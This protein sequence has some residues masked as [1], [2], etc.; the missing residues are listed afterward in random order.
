MK[1]FI[2]TNGRQYKA[3]EKKDPSDAEI[4]FPPQD[5]LNALPDDGSSMNFID[6]NER[7]RLKDVPRPQA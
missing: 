2:D 6:V 7:I 4:M 5:L 3:D 1:A